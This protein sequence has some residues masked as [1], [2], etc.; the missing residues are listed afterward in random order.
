MAN[1][2]FQV[3][4]NSVQLLRFCIQLCSTI[5]LFLYLLQFRLFDCSQP[6]R[7]TG[8][9]ADRKTDRGYSLSDRQMDE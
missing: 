6:Y 1:L 9:Q 3:P 4:M 8:R 2:V 7:Q 5:T